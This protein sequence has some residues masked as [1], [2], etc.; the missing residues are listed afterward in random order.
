MR[1]TAASI[2]AL[3]SGILGLTAWFGGV[4]FYEKHFFEPGL[5]VFAN[6]LMRVVF[7]ALLV[8]MIYVSGHWIVRCLALKSD[9]LVLSAGERL[10][11]GFTLGVGIWHFILL[12]LGHLSLYYNS[13]MIAISLV[14]LTASGR[15]FGEVVREGRNRFVQW[16]KRPSFNASSVIILVTAALLLII[17]GLYPG[18]SGD[19][20][21][22]YF[23][24][25][26]EVLKNHGLAPNDVWYHFFYSQGVGL[27]FFG[28]LL[29]DPEAPSLA[30]YVCVLIASL[31]LW[32]LSARIAPRSIWPAVAAG[33]YMLFCTI[34]LGGTG[35]DF[36]KHHEAATALAVLLVWGLCMHQ[37]APQSLSRL[38]LAVT[39][40]AG[41][42]ATIISLPMGVIFGPF[43]LLLA[44][45]SLTG[46]KW[47]HVVDYALVGIFIC[48][49]TLAMLLLNYLVAGLATDQAL[50]QALRFANLERLDRWGVLPQIVIVAW[51]RDNYASLAVSGGQVIFQ[52]V[53][54]MRIPLLWV[55][56]GSVLLTLLTIAYWELNPRY[57]AKHHASSSENA[58]ENGQIDSTLSAR[59]VLKLLGSLV[60]LLAL[61]SLIVG[62]SQAVSYT[63]FSTFFFFLIAL[64]AV[65]VWG[66]AITM[67][68]S[69]PGLRDHRLIRIGIPVAI[70]VA[71]LASWQ[72][73]DTWGKR[74][75][76]AAANGFRYFS[77]QYSLAYAYSRQDVQHGGI[78][79]SAV[80]VMQRLPPGTPIWVTNTNFYCMVPDCVMQSVVSFKMS[81]RLDEVLNGTPERAKQLLMEAGINYFVF[82]KDEQLVDILPFSQLFAVG[83]I[84]R[85]LGI[86]WTDGRTWLLG[87][88]GPDTQIIDNQ[89]LEA[90]QK[91]LEEPEHSLFR[92]RE[93]LPYMSSVMRDL[94]A[95]PHPW[96]LTSFPWRFT[97][98]IDVEGASYGANWINST[99]SMARGG[100]GR[101]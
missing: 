98:Q 27:F 29:T 4:G 42:G 8:W 32:T 96:A 45:L 44:A 64:F 36:Q 20:Y 24:Y 92:F 51:I 1:R 31:C 66:I 19:Y 75:I 86:R 73:T 81:P 58:S 94:R 88:R 16:R 28:M 15:H 65:S 43:F 68:S 41:L 11:I 10:I 59:R 97:K 35:G 49:V 70:F 83:S 30:T 48:G 12:I 82:S 87:W 3:L 79:P 2:F 99:G 101:P 17:R 61:F 5:I 56:L 90:Y 6:N 76:T 57:L 100:E 14:V 47:R 22:H 78:N 63:R 91:R 38:F 52:L 74:L 60:I 89:F 53:H 25:Y 7:T 55:L 33:L 67:G 71:T 46:R 54:F 80:A 85:Y 9:L 72:I 18:G 62:R 39:A 23:Y 21:T 26:I 84:E 50:D 69:R 40:S 95:S 13:V 93:L 37:I 34:P 77:G